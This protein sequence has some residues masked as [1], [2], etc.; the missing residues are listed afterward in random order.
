MTAIKRKSGAKLC[1]APGA[2]PPCRCFLPDGSCDVSAAVRCVLFAD[3]SVLIPAVLL[4]G[5]VTVVGFES[6]NVF[7]SCRNYTNTETSTN[8]TE[9]AH[10]RTLV[11]PETI[12]EIPDSLLTY[13]QQ[14]ETFLSN[15]RARS[16][17]RRRS[18]GVF[19]GLVRREHRQGRH[20]LSAFRF[21]IGCDEHRRSGRHGYAHHER[22][23]VQM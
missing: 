17:V 14:P 18:Q 2:V 9:R 10:L 4:I 19:V 13:C 1:L 5:G 23:A 16:A 22:R 11:L 20:G 15:A 3:Q 8:Q 7:A 21:G 12:Q 6:W